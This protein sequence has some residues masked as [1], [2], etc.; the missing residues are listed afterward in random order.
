MRVALA[1]M[2]LMLA[3][4]VGLVLVRGLAAEAGRAAWE[5]AKQLLPVLVLALIIAGCVEVLLPKG[6]VERWLSD[7]SGWRGIAVAW[8]AGILTPAG[9]P[10][11]LPVVAGF[12]RAGVGMPVLVTYLV[13]LSTLSL[14]RLP[15]ELG[16]IGSR[17]ALLRFGACLLLPPLAG[18][19]TRAALALLRG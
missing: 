8:V 11:G 13:S 10:V 12:A 15:M 3:G 18:L 14:M 9:G 1:V 7:A 16:M 4:L 19:L 6:W 5:Q 2:G 17:L